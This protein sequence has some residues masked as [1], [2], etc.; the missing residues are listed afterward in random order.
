MKKRI[1]KSYHRQRMM[2][3][4]KRMT[5]EDLDVVLVTDG[6][7]LRYLAGYTGS[8]GL[9]VVGHRAAEFITD[10]R[11]TVQAQ[12]QVRGAKVATAAGDL[13]EHLP[14]VDLLKRGRKKIGY[15]DV[16][17]PEAR[18]RKLREVLPDAL[19]I[20]FAE[21]VSPLMVVKD[22]TE[23]ALIQAAATIADL[24]FNAALEQIK[25]GVRERDV[26]LE[27]EYAMMKAG[28]EEK[29]FDTIVA[30]GPRAAL[31]HGRASMRR[32]RKG[33]F[34]TMDFGATVEGYVSDITRT[35]VVGKPTARQKR[36]YDLVRRA[37]ATAVRKARAGMAC[38]NLDKVAR[39]IIKRAGHGKRFGHGL[40]HGLGLQVHEGPAVNAKSKTIL[41]PGMVITI[42]PGVYFPGWGGVRIEDDVVV[43]RSGNRVLTKSDRDLLV[44]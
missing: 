3:L 16:N 42:E 22:P 2:S 34:V 41:K 6:P 12:S 25:P 19:F 27:M 11:Y 13:A 20:G 10:S 15:E 14:E 1:A 33:D 32:I 26:A 24:G 36:V 7:Q 28:S 39:N 35:V 8:N 37:Q 30:S 21:L 43:T 9:L 29:A 38:S 5:V 23:I 4:R 40:G 31:P 18:A 44:L 17:I